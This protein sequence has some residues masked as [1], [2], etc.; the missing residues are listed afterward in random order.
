[1]CDYPKETLVKLSVAT[2]HVLCTVV[3][4]VS[5]TTQTSSE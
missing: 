5:G 4:L 2:N 1:M 3:L